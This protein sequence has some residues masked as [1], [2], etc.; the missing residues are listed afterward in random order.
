MAEQNNITEKGGISVETAHIFPIIKRWLYSEK[1]I[2]LRE[3]VSN[4][5]DAITK[6]KRL[7]SLGQAEC[8][9]DYKITVRVDKTAGTLT[10]EDN[11]I[12]MS[13]DE[14]RR[15]I[16]QIALSGALEFIQKYEGGNEDNKENSGIIGHFGLG[17]YSS[18]MV[19][20]RVEI[21]TLSYAGG[22]P[23]H[24]SCTDD[25]S[26]EISPSE[27]TSRGTAV[28]MHIAED[29]A[30]YLDAAKVR[31]MLEKYCA[32]MPYE[33]YLESEDDKEGKE[34]ADKPVNDTTP[35]WLKKPSECTEEEY[36]E[37]YHKVFSD[38]NDPLFS[39]HINADY[40]LNFKGILYFPKLRSEY[41]SLE[42]Q[43][44]LYYNQV[45]VADNVKEIMPEYLIMLRGVIDCPELP[46]NVSRSYLQ[47]NTYV[48]RVSAHIVKKIADKVN[49]LCN[50]EREK[51]EKIWNDIRIF[52]E[53]AAV[54]DRKFFDRVKDSV[55]MKLTDGSCVT[56]EEYFTGK[57]ADD[58][59]EK[60]VENVENSAETAEAAEKTGEAA[61]ADEKAG[62]AAEKK[63]EVRT[64]FYTND[65][66]QQSQYISL[67]TSQG[68]KVAV[69]DHLVDAQFIQSAETVYD[70]L[71]FVRVDADVSKLTTGDSA[72]E[73]KDIAD[74]FRRVTGND[75]LEVRFESF[76][77]SDAPALLNL[78]EDQ[79]R[80]D[81]FMKAYAFMTKSEA[82][83]PMAPQSL[84]LN[85]ASPLYAHLCEVIESENGERAEFM[86]GYIWRLSLM[87]HRRLEAEELNA[88][89]ADSYKLL[90]NY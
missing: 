46:L 78:N 39:I 49:A 36:R 44:K 65:P 85:T 66:A 25:G 54:R 17:F 84:I 74:L 47:N 52:I 56:V 32:F 64:V 24:W 87:A 26:Y 67:Y 22:A 38:F 35:L 34:G 16:C 73:N 7:C 23:V 72:A 69:L 51:Y 28:I 55:L 79:R 89:L 75:K 33:I 48:S 5:A 57:K 83:A 10:V 6:M 27:R 4:A 81:D 11:G 50:T 31:S 70:K 37:F 90:G 40:P 62:E 42:G 59:A 61:E 76:K 58:E 60:P 19:A 8:S 3:I 77:D 43:V 45:F 86:A 15:Y 13:A 29:E 9:D 1:D 18:F 14:L 12:G 80:M 41:D 82:A 71:R 20:D 88:F 21:D 68:V 63:D 30:E 53:Y 2:F